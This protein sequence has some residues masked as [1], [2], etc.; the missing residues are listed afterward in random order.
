MVKK[1]YLNKKINFLWCVE[2][3]LHL[4]VVLELVVGIVFGV[5]IHLAILR[6]VFITLTWQN[7]DFD[8]KIN[9]SRCAGASFHPEVV[10]EYVVGIVPGVDDFQKF[11]WDHMV[12]LLV[13]DAL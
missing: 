9:L 10:L 5:G 7:K 11:K 8:T 1:T 4:E 3:K 12:F 6:P 13:S 2:A